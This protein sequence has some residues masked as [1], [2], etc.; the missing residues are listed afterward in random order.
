[1]GLEDIMV[2]EINH[3]EKDT[4]YM[5]SLLCG[6]QKQS[7]LT[8]KIKQNKKQTHR[9]RDWIGGCQDGKAVGRWAEWV[10]AV[11]CMVTD[12]S[13][14]WGNTVIYDDSVGYTGVQI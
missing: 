14:I 5:I 2:S 4:D 6:I 10:M 8:N 11:N 3:T 9:Y 1:M 12:G 13:Y 7:T